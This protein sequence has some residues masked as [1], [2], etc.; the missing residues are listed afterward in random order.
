MDIISVILIVILVV[1]A[2]IGYIK[3][4]FGIVLNICKGL[5]SLLISFFLAKPC[6]Q[7]LSNLGLGNFIGGKLENWIIKLAP[8]SNNIVNAENVSTVLKDTLTSINIPEFLHGII[9]KLV[10]NQLVLES[11]N[12]L[13]HNI[14][15]ALATLACTM[16]AFF[17]LTIILNVL[18]FILRKFFSHINA[19]PILGKVNRI[20]GLVL[21]LI[22]GCV[23]IFFVFWG[24]SFVATLIPDLQDLTIKWFKLEE[25]TMTLAKWFYENNLFVK[26]FEK[27]IQKL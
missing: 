3:G 5:S 9:E 7:F 4:F 6:G 2:M 14:G 23:V 22:F 25:E 16:I 26:I 10:G 13:A 21:N 8:V 12:T 17:L 20:L 11:D 15:F 19:V 24:L 18:F 27:L 1:F